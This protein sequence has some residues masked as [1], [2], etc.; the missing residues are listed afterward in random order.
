MNARRIAVSLIMVCLLILESGAVCWGSQAVPPRD[1]AQQM[2]QAIQFLHQVQN[3]D[4]GFP[5]T[6]GGASSRAATSWVVMGLAAA[7]EQA[8]GSSWAPAGNTPL[9]YLKAHDGPLVETNEYARLLLALSAA[10]QQPQYQGINLQENIAAF[11]QSNGQF[12]QLDKEEA[13]LINAHMWSVLALASVG[14]VPNP[15]LARAWLLGQQNSDGGFGWVEGI[16]SDADDTGIAIQ[17]LVLLG[18]KP[19]SAVTQKAILYLK[20]CQEQ[21]GGLSCGD[22]WMG[23]ESNAASDAWGILGL[24]AAGE[25]LQAD[26]WKVNGKTPLDH[27]LSLQAG[28]GSVYWKPQVD[29]ARITM[30]AYALMVMAK[31]PFPVNIDY[32][33]R[34]ETAPPAAPGLNGFTDFKPGDYGY[35]AVRA[36]VDEGV[37]SGYQDGSFRPANPVSRAEFAKIIVNGLG[38][39]D[40]LEP[41]AVSF[42]DVPQDFWANRY[43]AICAAKCD[44]EGLGDG[45]FDPQGKISGAQLAAILVRALPGAAAVEES[46]GDLWYSGYVAQAGE[47]GLLY[48][49]FE[50]DSPASRAQCAYSIVQLRRHLQQ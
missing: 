37:L 36:L 48:P 50:A 33:S 20:S 24:I 29:S 44:I 17:A 18:E 4:G 34:P 22:E 49:G 16:A 15:E 11:Q 45:T 21:D 28:D 42:R 40:N 39:E 2:Q 43:I 38:L 14:Q 5:S 9:D 35:E 12:A 27:L 1:C 8:S 10:G 46:A 26:K 19:N 47:N 3:D 7:G 13:G 6:P 32:H 25:N 30:T 31:K 41:G 23:N